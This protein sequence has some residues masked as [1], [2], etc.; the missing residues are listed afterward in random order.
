MKHTRETTSFLKIQFEKLNKFSLL[1]N[2]CKSTQLHG[3]NPPNYD[4]FRQCLVYASLGKVQEM[5]DGGKPLSVLQELQFIHDVVY[6]VISGNNC[7]NFHEINC[8]DSSGQM[9]Y[10]LWFTKV[11][12]KEQFSISLERMQSIDFKTFIPCLC[13]SRL[14]DSSHFYNFYSNDWLYRDQNGKF[15]LPWIPKS[16]NIFINK[17]M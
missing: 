15:K 7:V 6:I 1:R 13:V 17:N 9:I 10:N 3:T 5:L 8:D 14:S 12:V 16:I 2:L 11:T 4:R